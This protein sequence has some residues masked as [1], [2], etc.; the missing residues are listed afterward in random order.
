LLFEKR[1]S[2]V[3][4]GER[5][6]GFLGFADVEDSQAHFEEDEGAEAQRNE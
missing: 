6:L 5:V 1:I 4:A 2:R 3:E